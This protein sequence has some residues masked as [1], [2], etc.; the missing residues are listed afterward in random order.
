MVSRVFLTSGGSLMKPLQ[1][2]LA[3]ALV[4]SMVACTPTDETAPDKTG[5]E[6]DTS[7][8]DTSDTAEPDTREAEDT[9]QMPDTDDTSDVT[10]D[11]AQDPDTGPVQ[12]AGTTC[13]TGEECFRDVCRR[14]CAAGC[15]GEDVCVSDYCVDCQS[16]TDCSADEVCDT[17]S[18][19]CEPGLAVED[20]V[21]GVM[22]HQW[23]T[24]GRWDGDR[25]NYVYEPVLGHYDNGDQ[26]IVA[27]H[28]DW[29]E[30][31]GVNTWVLNAWI[32]DRD[33]SWVEPHS[34]AMMDEAD[35][36]AMKYFLL[37]DGWTEFQGGDSGYD[38]QAIAAKINQ[39]FAGWFERPGYLKVDGKPV[40]FF[41]AAWGKPCSLF[42]KIRA[43]IEG[44]LG[45]IYM[46][47][48]N[49]DESCW[50]RVMMYNPYTHTESTHAGQIARQEH[51]W[52]DMAGDRHPW[53]PTA[54][55]GYDDTHVRDGNPPIPLDADY[56]RDSIRTALSY[57]QH[58]DPWLFVCSWN[59]FHEGSNIEPSSDFNNPNIFLET[60]RDELERARWIASQ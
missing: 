48:N 59:E 8:A 43:G 15:G 30:Q 29:A 5:S 33:W 34:I 20:P 58:A 25:G 41:W 7:I 55:A 44:T 50:D 13:A 54:Q 56:F 47:G 57:D 46:T 18:Y 26:A 42:N 4:V 17:S 11:T 51:L 52:S 1:M 19:T 28:H 37:I 2:V 38:S 6:S 27:Q 24:P 39:R 12:C 10:E 14:P 53:A 9:T 16:D 31:A 45:P 49:G 23:W 36:R 3:A 22:Y 21:I 35:Q 32:T 40:V 60:L